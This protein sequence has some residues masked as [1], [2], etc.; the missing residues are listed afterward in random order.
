MLWTALLVWACAIL[1][2][3]SLSPSQ[4]PDAAFVFWD[5]VNHFVAFI[6]GGWLAATALRTSLWT[7]KAGLGRIRIT[8]LAVVIIAV[9]GFV[10]EGLQSLTP[11]RTGGDLL[12][13]IADVAG[14]ITGALLSLT[15]HRLSFRSNLKERQ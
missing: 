15:T 9:F 2:L 8:V 4:L 12:D 11:G 1:W 13:W 14:A 10:D 5:K 6:L 7:S 3:S